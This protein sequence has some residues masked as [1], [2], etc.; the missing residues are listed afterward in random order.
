M[1]CSLGTDI[2]KGSALFF[3][4]CDSLLE[5]FAEGAVL[6]AYMADNSDDRDWEEMWKMQGDEFLLETENMLLDLD[7]FVCRL[8]QYAYEIEVYLK[9]ELIGIVR[10]V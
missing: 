3:E 5:A 2:E 4:C 1:I 8:D 9:E 6:K 10:E 7:H